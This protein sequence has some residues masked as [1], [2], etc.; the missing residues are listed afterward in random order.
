MKTMKYK[1]YDK[2]EQCELENVYI[3]SD[4]TLLI[5]E[6]NILYPVTSGRMLEL[7]IAEYI[8]KDD[9]DG[10][11]IYNGDTIKYNYFYSKEYS[12]STTG[13]IKWDNKRQQYIISR[14]TVN[15]IM[16]TDNSISDIK[17]IG[18]EIEQISQ[19]EKET[20]QKLK[21]TLIISMIYRKKDKRKFGN[22]PTDKYEEAVSL[23]ISKETFEKIFERLSE[24]V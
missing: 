7:E 6:N 17:R 9:E 20:I 3:S 1:V 13:K 10:N 2:R 14:Y 11:E 16:L 21:E 23:T 4:G 18:H 22:I 8:G 24:L 12:S 5:K 15:D 19:S